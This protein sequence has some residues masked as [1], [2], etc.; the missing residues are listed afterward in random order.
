MQ[1]KISSQL[2]K[3]FSHFIFTTLSI[4]LNSLIA[5]G[6]L[7]I[8]GIHQGPAKFNSNKCLRWKRFQLKWFLTMLSHFTMFCCLFC[9][10][11]VYH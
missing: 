4:L 2:A 1:S 5:G 9:H 8:P 6:C 10:C 7:V 3:R 11:E